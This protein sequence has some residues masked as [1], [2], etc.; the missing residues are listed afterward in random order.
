MSNQ[1]PMGR[2][3]LENRK[4]TRNISACLVRSI[5]GW[6]MFEPHLAS[7]A[8]VNSD[9]LQGAFLSVALE[10]AKLIVKN[11][12]IPP[13][14]DG[15]PSF[16]EKHCDHPYFFPSAPTEFVGAAILKRISH[17]EWA[18]LGS[19]FIVPGWFESAIIDWANS[20]SLPL[21]NHEASMA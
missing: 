2:S 19:A 7:Y 5:M 13:S 11:V 4:L 10:M 21:N 1:H 18:A 15:A 3:V 12:E 8:G 14:N 17:D 9:D 20:Q 6:W 16:L